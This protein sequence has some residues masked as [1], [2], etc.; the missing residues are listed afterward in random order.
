LTLE[1][2]AGAL[3]VRVH[4]TIDLAE[5]WPAGALGP[6]FEARPSGTQFLSFA[7]FVYRYQPAD[8]APY[9][10][11]DIRLGVASGSSWMPLST[12]IGAGTASAQVMHLSTYGLIASNGQESD[13]SALPDGSRGT[14]GAAGAGTVDGGSRAGS[15]NGGGAP[16]FEAGT[17]AQ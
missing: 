2:P 8:I 10:P 17:A 9:A 11:T 6:V 5:A 16:T 13:A 15:G 3:M 12:T 14:G 7:T 1:V 4:L